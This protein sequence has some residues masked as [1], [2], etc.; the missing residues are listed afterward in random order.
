ML[1]EVTGA[2]AAG[3][4]ALYVYFARRGFLI[5][6]LHTL[7]S[8]QERPPGPNTKRQA[9]NRSQAPQR[10]AGDE[11]GRTSGAWLVR[12]AAGSVDGGGEK[13]ADVGPRCGRRGGRPVTIAAVVAS[14]GCQ[15]RRAAAAATAADRVRWGTPPGP[16]P[17][18]AA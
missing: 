17:I 13:S 4:C 14:G 7:S 8:W 15:V 10:R 3:F 2:L 6:L 11:K 18:N 1:A 9:V 16:P 12:G 5:S